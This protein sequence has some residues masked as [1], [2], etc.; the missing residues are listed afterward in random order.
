MNQNL[1]R[2]ALV[3]RPNVGKSTL[4]NRLLGQH[5]AIT[6]E[7]AGTTR[8]RLEQTVDLGRLHF[9]LIDVGGIEIKKGTTLEDDIQAQARYAIGSADL[10]LFL[11]D[12]KSELTAD[13]HAAAEILRK[14]KKPV[15]FTANKWETGNEVDLLNFTRLGLGLPLGISAV[16]KVG[17][18]ELKNQLSKELR[19]LRRANQEVTAAA[20]KLDVSAN[21]ALVGRP[22]V[23]K[24][25]LVNA[26]LGEE[27]LIVSD[28][29]G[30]T[31]DVNDIVLEQEGQNYRLLDTAGM[32]R[33]GRIG[34]GLDRFATG[35]TLNALETADVALLLLDGAEGITAQD[36]HV[37]EQ[38]VKS[39]TGLLIVVN[40]V[41]IWEDYE[42]AQEKWLR[43]L[44]ERFAFA[45]WLPVVMISTKSGKNLTHILPRVLEIKAEAAKRIPTPELN[46]LFKKIVADHA[47]SGGTRVRTPLR[48]FY[49]TQAETAPP[50][51]V[52]F[53]NNARGFHF[54]YRR[55]IENRLREEYGFYGVPV[56][57]EL[58]ERKRAPGSAVFTRSVQAAKKQ[59]GRR[60]APIRRS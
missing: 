45:P 15:I 51:F 46:R 24:S 2:V 34:T 30:T 60:K 33:R 6:A 4:F 37:A 50:T 11:I 9:T 47:P 55:Y 10:V 39:G 58:R 19:K 52:L 56:R 35:R 59:G 54:S 27:R 3:G 41:D 14:Q 43:G 18:D 29:P 40:K 49:A 12:A 23:G 8:D 36:L 16:H 38:I 31:R 25:S 7:E 28:I 5:L 20:P 53:V 13:D 57:L 22:N 42:E 44:R 1:L 17:L 26:L 21:L 32:K 48:I